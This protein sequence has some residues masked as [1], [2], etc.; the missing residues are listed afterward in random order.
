M[1]TPPSLS[2]V[3][4]ACMSRFVHFALEACNSREIGE[5][6]P[7]R[8][9]LLPQH[10]RLPVLEFGLPLVIEGALG[11][12]RAGRLG[13]PP[14]S[15][16]RTVPAGGGALTTGGTQFNLE[17]STNLRVRGLEARRTDPQARGAPADSRAAAEDTFNQPMIV[18]TSRLMH[19][20]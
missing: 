15:R 10:D 11:S 5:P 6:C 3:P 8:H 19:S 9:G 4:R 20:H 18:S 12:R 13:N 14:P 2:P 17:H 16:L 7:R 1:K